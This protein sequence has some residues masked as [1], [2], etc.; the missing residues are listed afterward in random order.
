M[1]PLRDQDVVL[2]AHPADGVEQ[3]QDVGVDVARV[4]GM[5]EEVAL[6]VL[7]AEVAVVGV[8]EVT[9]V[10]VWM[11]QTK[12]GKGREIEREGILTCR[13]R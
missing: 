9:T 6:E 1:A 4:D 13:A 12:M 7:A 2:D 11:W 10:W 3:L 5:I 8:R